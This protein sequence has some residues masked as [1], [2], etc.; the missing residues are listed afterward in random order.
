[1]AEET[2]PYAVLAE[3]IDPEPLLAGAR[4][5][6]EAGWQ[7]EVFSPFPLD[8]LAEA[9]GWRESRIPLAFLIGAIV[10][11]ALG[12]LMQV[13][14]NLD[15]PLDVGGRPLIAVPSFLMI[16]FETM[17]LCSVFAG[18]G[19]MLIENRLPRL[20]HPIFDAERFSLATD[21]RFFLALLAG[22]SFDAYEARAA[23][24]QLQPVNVSEVGERE[25]R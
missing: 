12:F 17:V 9:L 2:A 15:Y 1:M 13:G 6:R 22:E 16:T 25:V 24:W 11:A 4:Q 23:L 14:T 8:G 10:G 5:L 7:I 3:F 20:H 19:T 18:I 21:D